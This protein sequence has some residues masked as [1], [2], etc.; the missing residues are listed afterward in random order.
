M[1]CADAVNGW[2]TE[3]AAICRARGPTALV[4]SG[5]E[6]RRARSSARGPGPDR[7]GAQPSVARDLKR[8]AIAANFSS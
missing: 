6:E 1:A 8:Q 4:R 5:I 2:L 7:C 3:R